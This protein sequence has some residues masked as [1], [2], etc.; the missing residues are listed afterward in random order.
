MGLE[1]AKVVSFKEKQIERNID[2]NRPGRETVIAK[3]KELI[4]QLEEGTEFANKAIVFLYDDDS[5]PD[6]P[7]WRTEMAGASPIEGVGFSFI[8]AEDCRVEMLPWEDV[9]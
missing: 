8:M 9:D 3:L 5:D 6:Y 4:G 2:L 7:T 1:L